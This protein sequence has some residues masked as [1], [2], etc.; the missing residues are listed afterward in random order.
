MESVLDYFSSSRRLDGA[1]S[2]HRRVKNPGSCAGLPSLHLRV[3]AEREMAK[4]ETTEMLIYTMIFSIPTVSNRQFMCISTSAVL[5]QLPNHPL[6]P[7][8][9][10]SK[11]GG[12]LYAIVDPMDNQGILYLSEKEYKIQIRV[13]V[14]QDSTLTVLAR[15]GDTQATLDL[16]SY[17]STDPTKTNQNSPTLRVELGLSAPRR[18]SGALA[19]AKPFNFLGW[20]ISR[21][22]SF[23]S[24]S[25]VT[26]TS[27]NLLSLLLHWGLDLDVRAGGPMESQPSMKTALVELGRRLTK[28]L[29]T[30]GRTALIQKMKNTLFFVNRWLGGSMNVDPFLLGEPVGL[31]RSGLPRILPLYLRRGLGSRNPRFIRIVCSLLRAYSALEG[32]HKDSD[33]VSVTGSCPPLCQETL[34]EFKEF[35]LRVFW[36]KVIRKYA[37]EA[38]KGWILEPQLCAKP[39]TSPYHPSR[40]GPNHSVGVL[41]A[42]MDALAWAACPINY[43]LEWAAHVGDEKTSSLFSQVLQATIH[44]QDVQHR[45]ASEGDVYKL[46]GVKR[47]RLLSSKDTGRLA[48]LPEAAGKVRTIAMADYWTQRLMKPVHD[49]MMSVL[50]VLPTDATFDQER[51]LRTYAES[52][53]TVEKHFS[54]DLKSATDMIPIDLYHALLSGIWKEETCDL[55]IGLMTDRWFRVPK[56]SS[57]D[58]PL[59][60]PKLRGTEVQ[61][62]RGQ[63]MGTLSSWASMALVH[64]ALELFSASKAG[65]D[66]MTFTSY[67]VLGDDNV[68]GDGRVAESYLSVCER[69]QIPISTSKT[70]EGK[71]F[72]FASQSYLGGENISPMSL[73]EELS[74]RTC[75]QRLEMALR[76]YSRGWFDKP[77]S[78]KL[79]RHLLRRRDYLRSVQEFEKGKLGRVAQAALI[80]AFVLTGRFTTRLGVGG[81]SF[82]P[83]LLSMENKVRALGGDECHLHPETRARLD[84]IESILAISLVRRIKGMLD[85]DVTSLKRTAR[86]WKEWRSLVPMHGFPVGENEFSELLFANWDRVPRDGRYE[87]P[88]RESWVTFAQAVMPVLEDYYQYYFAPIVLKS[89]RPTLWQDNLAKMNAG[90]VTEAKRLQRATRLA[91]QALRSV[92]KK[93]VDGR[94]AYQAL[95]LSLVSLESP[96]VDTRDDKAPEPAAPAPPPPPRYGDPRAVHEAIQTWRQAGDLLDR[97]VRGLED[98]RPLA[99]SMAKVEEIMELRSKIPR[100]ETLKDLQSLMP[101]RTP[102]VARAASTW[103]R[104]IR[105]YSDV[106][107]HVDLAR[108]FSVLDF[109]LIGLDESEEA[110]RSTTPETLLSISRK[111]SVPSALRA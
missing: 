85:E 19:R 39:G 52:T 49:W 42:P 7:N 70:L 69:L 6:Y 74:V 59:V 93:L 41:G 22:G 90:K 2:S 24:Q 108:D 27:E 48:F 26:P 84:E 18:K 5:R 35:C 34:K 9:D 97:L 75:S 47:W 38:G 65:L 95:Q 91:G 88:D 109:P 101:E 28:I 29:V 8:I 14:S 76:A 4:L 79:L 43:P 83:F 45:R 66:P 33:L 53:K 31:A 81:S 56:G 89:S 46:K 72:V 60:V 20:Y 110:L 64:H 98:G 87:L 61:Y 32:P 16:A 11:V 30:R 23:S 3:E 71:L 58:E 51:G 12:G 21:L 62:N 25:L 111:D 103:A 100:L 92:Y 10:W 1:G 86:R 40:G 50:S 15:P 63:P 105:A 73:K 104:T 80:S 57:D 96:P 77:T 102:K 54:I 36:P 67:R 94:K 37:I 106:L 44:A 82:V 55:W 78:A 13:T 17:A 68:T 99:N 107:R